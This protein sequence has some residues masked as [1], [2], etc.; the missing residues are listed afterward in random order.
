MGV[1]EEPVIIDAWYL[2]EGGA[3]SVGEVQGELE[4]RRHHHVIIDSL[5]SHTFRN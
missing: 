3:Q 4:L 5:C 1:R 2:N